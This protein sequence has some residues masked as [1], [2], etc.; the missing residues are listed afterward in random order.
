MAREMVPHMAR[1]IERHAASAPARTLGWS[2]AAIAVA[3]TCS[4]VGAAPAPAP[5][6]AT[7]PASTA[8]AS[9]GPTQKPQA[10]A[11]SKAQRP[12]IAVTDWIAADAVRLVAGDDVDVVVVPGLGASTPARTIDATLPRQTSPNTRPGERGRLDGPF[13]L[14]D[15]ARAAIDA[16]D[17]LL[18]T[19]E[20]R[21]LHIATRDICP[22]HAALVS[23]VR[24]QQRVKRANGVLEPAFWLDAALWART[25]TVARQTLAKIEPENDQALKARAQEVRNALIALNDEMLLSYAKLPS[26]AVLIVGAEGLGQVERVHQREVREVPMSLKSEAEQQEMRELVDLIIARKIPVVFPID[27]APNANLDELVKRVK[28]R[29]GDVR[30]GEPLHV[31]TPIP[32]DDGSAGAV[33]RMIRH[34]A[35]V[36][37]DGFTPKGLPAAK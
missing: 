25:A 10:N 16:A 30:L 18:S 11:P 12:V 8:P 24:P 23:A 32:S 29:G 22:Q 21:E 36:V 4:W 5:P 34:N 1:H 26:D 27:G 13:E 15:E 9:P 19:N 2:L 35:R 6:A 31:D 17:G 20:S 37:R 33:E 14:A 3:A 7:A 28:V